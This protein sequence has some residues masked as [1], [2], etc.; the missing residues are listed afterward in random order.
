VI[1]AEAG[2]LDVA[3]DE[4]FGPAPEGG[5]S[6]SIDPRAEAAGASEQATRLEPGQLLIGRPWTAYRIWNSG[7]EPASLL[8]V[9]MRH[10]SPVTDYP[11]PGQETFIPAHGVEGL[12]AAGNPLR[13]YN[14]PYNLSPYDLAIGHALLPPGAE[15]PAH[16]V[17]GVELITVTRGLIDVSTGEGKVGLEAGPQTV[18]GRTTLNPGDGLSANADSE[19]SFG[20]AGPEPTEIWFVTLR[21]DS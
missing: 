16:I 21:P 9:V 8:F 20:A 4:R 10:L 14:G 3:A 7:N 5:A 13:P 2:T 15:I 6:P 11:T 12:L 18:Q 1:L 17:A 19:T